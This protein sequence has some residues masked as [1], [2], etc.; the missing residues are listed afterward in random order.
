M[1]TILCLVAVGFIGCV[2]ARQDASRTSSEQKVVAANDAIRLARQACE[3]K[4]DVPSHVQAI[5]TETNGHL[6]VVFPQPL[7]PDVLHGDYYARV[8]I[9]RATGRIVEI[10]ASP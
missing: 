9:E 1:M 8:T 2:P 5:V 10:L 4:V 7:Q 6:V 3:G